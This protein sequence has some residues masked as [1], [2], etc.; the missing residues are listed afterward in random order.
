[1]AEVTALHSV[2]VASVGVA[3]VGVLPDVAD[4]DLAVFRSLDHVVAGAPVEVVR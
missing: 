2:Q 1:M 3:D 4:E